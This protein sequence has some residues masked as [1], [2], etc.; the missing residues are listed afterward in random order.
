MEEMQGFKVP[1]GVSF[2]EAIL[3]SQGIT[4]WIIDVW[5]CHGVLKRREDAG[6]GGVPE[7]EG[8]SWVDL[9]WFTI[10]MPT[11]LKI[12]LIKEQNEKIERI[13]FDVIE[14]KGAINISGFYPVFSTDLKK[15]ENIIKEE[16]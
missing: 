15:I 6:Y 16:S 14:R 4:S 10:P 7:E 12:S 11:C 9:G 8:V 3:S 1:K 2:A 13:L 5:N